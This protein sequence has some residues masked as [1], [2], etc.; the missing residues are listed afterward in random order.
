M[1]IPNSDRCNHCGHPS[2]DEERGFRIVSEARFKWL[3]E[4]VEEYHDMQGDDRWW[5]WEQAHKKLLKKG[6]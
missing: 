2:C 6:E 1:K 4:A 3:L 5:D